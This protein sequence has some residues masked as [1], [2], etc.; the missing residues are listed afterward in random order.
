MNKPIII[1]GAGGH[2]SV[3]ADIAILLGRQ[4]LGLCNPIKALLNGFP[5]IAYLGNDDVLSQ[6]DTSQVV[7][8]NGLGAISV[9]MNQQR[10]MLFQ[11]FVD[12]GYQFETL[13]HPSAVVA[14]SSQLGQGTQVMAGAIIQPNVIIKENVIINTGSC[15]DHDCVISH[16]VHIAPRV[17]LSGNTHLGENSMVGVGAVIIQGIKIEENTMIRAGSVVTKNILVPQ[18]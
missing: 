13:I 18:D 7:L 8:V 6:Y 5:N 14:N 9:Q 10:R 4:I 15:V 1:L 12:I 11:K 3:L 16:S 17:V 2:A